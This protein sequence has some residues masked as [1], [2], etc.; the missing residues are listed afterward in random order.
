MPT[1]RDDDVTDQAIRASCCNNSALIPE[2]KLQEN[3][4]RI[5]NS[6][7]FFFVLTPKTLFPHSNLIYVSVLY[8]SKFVKLKLEAVFRQHAFFYVHIDNYNFC[9]CKFTIIL[10]FFINNCVYF[11]RIRKKNRFLFLRNLNGVPI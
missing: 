1:Q 3:S 7:S 8:N 2:K 5:C 11:L 10:S 9:K 6:R 4:Q